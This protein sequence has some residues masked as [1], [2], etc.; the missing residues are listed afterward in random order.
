VLSLSRWVGT[1]EELGRKTEWVGRAH[2]RDSG[3]ARGMVER[4]MVIWRIMILKVQ[5]CWETGLYSQCTYRTVQSLHTEHYWDCTVLYVTVDYNDTVV[6]V[7][8]SAWLPEPKLSIL[9]S[10][11]SD[12]M[13][14]VIGP[15]IGW[16]DLV[17]L[18]EGC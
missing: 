12:W 10:T 6:N 15:E 16:Y 11:C 3:A 7:Y 2:R 14:Q 13:F 17:P 4:C 8:C 5:S 1:L 9:V 18:A